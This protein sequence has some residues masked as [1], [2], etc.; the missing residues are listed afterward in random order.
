MSNPEFTLTRDDI[1]ARARDMVPILQERSEQAESAR[2]ISEETD[3]AFRDAEFYKIMQPSAYGGLELDFGTQT[4]LAVIL[5]PGCASSAWVAS[6]TACHGWI[7]GMFPPAAQTDVWGKKSDAS[8]A[9]SFLPFGPDIKRV[10]GGLHINGRW[11]FSSGVDYC[12]WA[13]LT[14]AEIGRASCRE[15][16]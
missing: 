8:V 7:L 15:R 6:V 1:L 5:G 2:R 9:S 10:D 16:V 13:V 14:M 12:S 11:G 4:E 3:Q